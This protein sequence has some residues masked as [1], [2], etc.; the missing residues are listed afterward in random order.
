[1][2]HW[3]PAKKIKKLAYSKLQKPIFFIWYLIQNIGK[4]ISYL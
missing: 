4:P 2:A 1:M 3:F